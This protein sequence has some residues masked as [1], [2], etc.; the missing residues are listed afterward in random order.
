VPI[1]LFLNWSSRD[2]SRQS[3]LPLVAKDCPCFL[4]SKEYADLQPK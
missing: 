4:P 2:G 1:E 3:R